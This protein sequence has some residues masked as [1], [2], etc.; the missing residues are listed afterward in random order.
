MMETY[1]AQA[2]A[3]E[4]EHQRTSTECS[5]L[6]ERLD[7]ST[8]RARAAETQLLEANTQCEETRKSL[9][10]CLQ[11]CKK[12]EDTA[13]RYRM[14]VLEAEMKGW[15]RFSSK[16]KERDKLNQELKEAKAM[17]EMYRLEI[18]RMW[19]D[20]EQID[21]M[22]TQIKTLEKQNIALTQ[23]LENTRV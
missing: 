21:Y 8:A 15:G 19:P 7:K 18:N 12:S 11:Q 3:A 16:D 23:A 1:Q 9:E 5:A 20:H 2:E 17:A 22:L 14:Q 10:A 6:R 4:A 13:E